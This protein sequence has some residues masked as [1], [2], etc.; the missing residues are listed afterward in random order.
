MDKMV[1]QHQQKFVSNNLLTRDHNR[2]KKYYEA[3][4]NVSNRF[5]ISQ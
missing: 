3:N 4:L 1:Y 2:L 5:V